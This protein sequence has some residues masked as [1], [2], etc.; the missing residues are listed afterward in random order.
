MTKGNTKHDLRSIGNGSTVEGQVGR[1]PEE[2][3][4]GERDGDN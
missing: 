1:E 2:E 4:E 3:K